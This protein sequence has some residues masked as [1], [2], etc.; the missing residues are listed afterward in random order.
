MVQAYNDLGNS[1]NIRPTLGGGPALPYPRRLATNRPEVDGA[2]VP[3]LKG[4]A[5]LPHGLYQKIC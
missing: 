3:P 1:N 4:K 5:W 2:E